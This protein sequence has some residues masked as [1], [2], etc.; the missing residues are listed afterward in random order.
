MATTKEAV[1]NTGT[2]PSSP[3]PSSCPTNSASDANTNISDHGSGDSKTL[4]VGV[5]VGV[6]LGVVSLISLIWGVYERRKR[7]QLLNSMPSM[8]PMN[9]DPYAPLAVAKNRYSEPQELAP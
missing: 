2:S 3:S 8:M 7:Q 1:S 4:P 5:G 6:S 9:S